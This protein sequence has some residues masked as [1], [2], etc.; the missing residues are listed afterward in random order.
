MRYTIITIG[1]ILAALFILQLV[2]GQ[3]FTA[4]VE[5]LDGNQYPLADLYVVGF[6]WSSTKLFAFRGKLAADLMNQASM[7]Y[8]PQYAEYYGNLVWAQAITLGHLFITLTFLLAGIIYSS[9]GLL[10]AL[11]VF[12]SVFCVVY[13]IEDMKNTLSKRT[14]NCERELAEVVSTMAILVNSGMVLRDV[15]FLISEKGKGNFYDLM[16]KATENMRNGYSDADAIY[17]F[18]RDSNSLEIKKFTS[19]LIQSMEKGGGELSVFLANESAELWNTKR[20]VMLQEGEKAATKLLMPIML[21][22]VGVIIIVIAA[23]FSGS[24]F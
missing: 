24:L 21:I 12:M 19:A 16:R 13:C 11:G 20:Q 3:K 23:A 18:G 6:T 4:M 8:E 10:L 22:F 17:M 1:T 7:L 15:W 5:N 14:T 9:F 2:R